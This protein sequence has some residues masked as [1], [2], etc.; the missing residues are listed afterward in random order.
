MPAAKKSE[1]EDN[2]RAATAAKALEEL[3][4]ETPAAGEADDEDDAEEAG[5]A[6]GAGEYRTC[7]GLQGTAAIRYGFPSTYLSIIRTQHTHFVT[8]EIG[9]EAKKK[10]KK[11]KPKKKSGPKQSDP[12]RVGLTKFFPSGQYPVGEECE[13]KDECASATSNLRFPSD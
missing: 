12:P 6:N 13:Y 5:E 9:G 11:K 1:E 3:K 2:L 10:K 8:H 7:L 4:L